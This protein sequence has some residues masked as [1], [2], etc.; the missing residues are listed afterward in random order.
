M[1]SVSATELEKIAFSL[2]SSALSS[3]AVARLALDS[4]LAVF[5]YPEVEF[6]LVGIG[7]PRDS[8]RPGMIE[9]I[10]KR[11]YQ[12]PARFAQWLP[13]QFAD[14]SFFI[15]LRVPNSAKNIANVPSE[16]ALEDAIALLSS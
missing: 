13:A 4:G 15:L 5:A 3:H 14:G 12:M 9:N 16:A 2:I 6:V 8:L 10:L 1:T 7:Y 11:R